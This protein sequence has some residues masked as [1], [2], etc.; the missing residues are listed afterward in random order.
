[1][2]MWRKRKQVVIQEVAGEGVRSERLAFLY[3]VGRNDLPE[4]VSPTEGTASPVPLEQV[5]LSCSRNSKKAGVPGAEW[6]LQRVTEMR[7]VDSRGGSR[8]F[9]FYSQ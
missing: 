4:G 5:C 9:G 1:M 7:A 8:A 6:V 2:A 3:K